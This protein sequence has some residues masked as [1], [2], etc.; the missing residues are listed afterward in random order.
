MP[1]EH[2]LSKEELKDDEF[3]DSLAKAIDWGRAH[4]Q[5][6]I[7]GAVAIVV[8]VLGVQYLISSQEK[9]RVEAAAELSKA[10]VAEE[11][12]QPAEAVRILSDQVLRRYEGTPS[13]GKAALMLANRHYAEGNYGDARSLFQKCLDD[14]AD[15]PVV[16][17]GAWAGLAACLEAEGKTQDAAR[18]YLEYADGHPK[19]V[20]AALSLSEA[21]RCFAQVGDRG[22]QKGVLE[23]LTKEYPKLPVAR[24]A[25]TTL[26]SL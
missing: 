7:G 15:N 20:E 17:Y 2:K 26:R 6:L 18:K 8:I 22:A 14:Y 9:A 11:G 25:E 23:R 1:G 24:T 13:A 5:Y 10:M 16:A 19:T 3:I 21:A 12:G 4:T